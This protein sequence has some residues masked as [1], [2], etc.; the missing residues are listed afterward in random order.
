MVG[1]TSDLLDLDSS[2]DWVRND[3]EIVSFPIH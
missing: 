2:D 1:I 3:S